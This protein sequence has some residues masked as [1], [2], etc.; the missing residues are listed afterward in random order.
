MEQTFAYDF[1]SNTEDNKSQL[2]GFKQSFDR[3]KVQGDRESK[4]EG[5]REERLKDN[6][7]EIETAVTI[8]NREFIRMPSLSP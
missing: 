4:T 8:W 6:E 1:L 3:T 7:T 2:T 5:L